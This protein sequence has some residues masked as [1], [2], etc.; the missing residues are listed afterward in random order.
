MQ[1]AFLCMVDAVGERC[2]LAAFALFTRPASTEF[3][4]GKRV[5][6]CRALRKRY[7][8]V[9]TRLRTSVSK[10]PNACS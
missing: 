8:V 3:A 10:T 4:P 1:N 7:V 6:D 2:G 9:R 5:W